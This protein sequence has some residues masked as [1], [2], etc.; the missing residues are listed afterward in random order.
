MDDLVCLIK[1]DKRVLSLDPNLLIG[2][3]EGKV[4]VL[5]EVVRKW[6]LFFCS[7]FFVAVV[8]ISVAFSF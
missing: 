6:T 2:L 3:A 5:V 4:V 7:S 8:R 1:I